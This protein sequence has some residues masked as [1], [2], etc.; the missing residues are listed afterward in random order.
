MRRLVIL[1]VVWGLLVGVSSSVCLSAPSEHKISEDVAVLTELPLPAVEITD[2]DIVLQ[3]DLPNDRLKIQAACTVRNQGSVPV[4]SLDFD[5]LGAE[6]FYG[7]QVEIAKISRLMGDQDTEAKFERFIE[8]NPEDPSQ[9]RTRDYPEVTRVHFSPGLTKG[10][11]CRLVFDY[12]IACVDIKKRRHYN[13]IWEPKEEEKEVCLMSDFSWFPSLMPT[14]SQEQR[15]MEPP[16]QKRN[17][18]AREPR[19]PWR[20]TLIH[21]AELEGVVIEGKLDDTRL[22]DGQTVSRWKSIVGSKPQLFIGPVE[23]I[24]KKGEKASVVFFLPK[25]KSNPEFVDATADL[26]LH[27]Y[28]VFADW[29]GPLES[30]EIRI[31]ANSGIPGGHG[32]FM[33]MMA[34]SWYFQLEKSERMKSGKFFE[35]SPVHE[36]AHS[37]WGHSVASYGRGTKFLRESLANF[38]TWHLAREYYGLDIFKE[39]LDE[40]IF[41]LGRGKKPLFNSKSDDD[42][43]SYRKGPLILDILRQEMGNDVFFRV[44]KEFARR[45]KNSHATF[46]DLVSVCNEVSRR[47]WMPFFYQW[48]YAKACPAYC[49]DSFESKQGTEGWETTVTISND[50]EGIVRC[51]LELRMEGASREENFWVRGGGEKTYVYSTDKEVQDI[52]IDP[53]QTTY[54]ADE[55]RNVAKIEAGEMTEEEKAA[56]EEFYRIKA[57]LERGETFEETST[58]LRALL[59]WMSAC[60]NRDTD[61]WSWWLSSVDILRAPLPP[62]D[63]KDGD[64]WMVYVTEQGSCGLDDGLVFICEKGK[65]MMSGNAGN[66]RGALNWRRRTSE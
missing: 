46:I 51:P 15:E 23:R 34:P 60:K 45:Y 49:L 11:E 7:V 56:I 1:N 54:Q 43:F 18:F 26:V 19:S 3:T 4:D 16:W 53:K 37:W 24:E 42:D 35:R 48:C 47:D 12:K 55:K 9:A 25:G 59:S 31:V 29:F 10:N 50:G 6:A 5:L 58:P 63:L 32:A 39:N 22:V 14:R 40:R 27:A 44:L 61:Y 41:D 21:P 38:A 52:V 57:K 30:T 36:L 33:G 13:L 17:F 20:V 65:W 62:K 8:H 2:W 64:E 66:A 28:V